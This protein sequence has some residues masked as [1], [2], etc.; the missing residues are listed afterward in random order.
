MVIQSEGF[1]LSSNSLNW[2]R[3][4]MYRDHSGEFVCGYYKGSY[5]WQLLFLLF[6]FLGAIFYA[7]RKF[8]E[9]ENYRW[10]SS[11]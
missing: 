5:L 11:N 2:L 8:T 10:R 4:E 3:K 9:S 7:V 6:L 1:D